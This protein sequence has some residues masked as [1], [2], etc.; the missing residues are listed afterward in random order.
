MII[1][2]D[3]IIEELWRYEWLKKMKPI[4]IEWQYCN[5]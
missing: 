5:E 2:N 1:I 3:I 4:M